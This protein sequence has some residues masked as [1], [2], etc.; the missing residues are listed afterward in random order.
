MPSS[1]FSFP[2][3][4]ETKTTSLPAAAK[5]QRYDND[6]YASGTPFYC[7]FNLVLITVPVQRLESLDPGTK[8]NFGLGSTVGSTF[9]LHWYQLQQQAEGVRPLQQGPVE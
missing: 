7:P 6:V 1:L 9:S 4:Y 3:L 8:I 5:V 2:G